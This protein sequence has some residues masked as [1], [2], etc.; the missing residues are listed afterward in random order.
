MTRIH[1]VGADDPLRAQAERL[2]RELGHEPLVSSECPAPD[3]AAGPLIA[4]AETL[5]PSGGIVTGIARDVPLVVYAEAPAVSEVVT[6]IRGGARD[7]LDAPITSSRGGSSRKA[8]RL[9]DV[10]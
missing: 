8:Q 2:L 10:T 1:L 9:S 3:A 5:T 7:Y 4:H 6:A